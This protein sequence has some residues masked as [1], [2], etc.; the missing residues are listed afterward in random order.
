MRYRK[1]N[2]RFCRLRQGRKVQTA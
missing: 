2:G 1:Q